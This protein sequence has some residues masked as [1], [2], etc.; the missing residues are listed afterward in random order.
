MNFML[1]K[2][3]ITFPQHR[4]FMRPWQWKCSCCPTLLR[5]TSAT[6]IIAVDSRASHL[7]WYE[8][9]ALARIQRAGFSWNVLP[10][11]I[12]VIVN[13]TCNNNDG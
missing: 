10:R 6:P 3:F 2:S 7:E 4:M 9:L 8:Q 13:S 12:H 11:C 1:R 5:I